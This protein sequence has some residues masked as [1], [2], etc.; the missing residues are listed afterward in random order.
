MRWQT[1]RGKAS[2]SPCKATIFWELQ[3]QAVA[4]PSLFS[5]QYELHKYLE[6]TDVTVLHGRWIVTL[7]FRSSILQTMDKVRWLRRTNH[8]TNERAGISN[9]RDVAKDRSISWCVSWS[10]HRR[11]GLEV[12]EETYGSVQCSYMYARALTPT[13]G[14]ESIIWLCKYAGELKNNFLFIFW[15]LFHMVFFVQLSV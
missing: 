4:R 1:S 2:V 15:Y 7:D 13:Y 9:L 10:D 8:Y 3:K 6:F 14:R 12:W 11:K 5:F